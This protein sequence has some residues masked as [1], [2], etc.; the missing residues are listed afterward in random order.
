VARARYVDA[1]TRALSILLIVAQ[2][3]VSIAAVYL[4]MLQTLSVAGCGDRCDYG[5]VTAAFRGTII[6]ASVALLGSI[7]VVVV[8]SRQGLPSWWA[9]V[10]GMALIAAAAGI[11]VIL[12]A[13]GTA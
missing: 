7:G 9:P 4:V 3:V 12:V 13:A 2:V 6:A 11:A 8:R 10:V 5:L 1:N